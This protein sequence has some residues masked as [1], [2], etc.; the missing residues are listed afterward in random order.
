MCYEVLI[1]N[2]Y[3]KIWQVFSATIWQFNFTLLMDPKHIHEAYVGLFLILM[4]LLNLPNILFS[5]IYHVRFFSFPLFVTWICLHCTEQSIITM[6]LINKN[7]IV[8]FKFNHLMMFLIIFNGVSK[9]ML[10]F[11]HMQNILTKCKVDYRLMLMALS[12]NI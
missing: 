9:D 10:T 3:S 7:V 11:C 12:L 8:L 4:V 5:P 1:L 6:L 2:A